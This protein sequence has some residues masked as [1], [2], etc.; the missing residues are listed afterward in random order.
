MKKGLGCRHF[1]IVFFVFLFS[2]SLFQCKSGQTEASRWLDPD[3]PNIAKEI[4]EILVK[5]TPKVIVIGTGLCDNCKI[6]ENTVEAFHKAHP[7]IPVPW[8]VYNHYEDRAT[9]QYFL[10]TVSPT[11][12]FI[13][14]ENY[15]QTK[16]IGAFNEEIYEETL[17]SVF[18]VGLP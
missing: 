11:T 17:R 3:S 12:F 4:R 13:D 1:F 8:M 2:L 7:E 15:I 9:F 6:V 18:P 5:D 14:Q 16:L 10:V